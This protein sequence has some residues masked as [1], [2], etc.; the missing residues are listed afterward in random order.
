MNQDKLLEFEK[1]IG[2]TFQN[3]PV[4]ERVFI[5]RS[6]L[7]ENKQKD[8]EHNERLEFLGDAVIELAVTEYLYK[9]FTHPEGILT[10]WRSAIVRGKSL[11]DEAKKIGL[12][13]M[14]MTSR[15]EAKNAGK[16]KDLLLANALEAL[17]G[18]IYL[19]QGFDIAKKFINDHIVYKL[20]D[21]VSSGQNID[22]KGRFQELSQEKFAITPT[23]K[24]LSENGPDHNKIFIV[25]LYLTDKKIAD[26]T[27]SSKQTAQV[28]AARNA[29]EVWDSITL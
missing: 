27:G 22:P 6:Y 15:G 10:N 16:A 8:L 21:V 14:L 17:I 2:I 25:G 26:G 9:N 18:A 13:N 24:V 19:D 5:H 3:R 23:Y 1:S 4:Y 20:D 29:L 28:E 12:D 7:N 11:S